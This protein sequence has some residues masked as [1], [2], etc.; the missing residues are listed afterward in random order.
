MEPTT[1][2]SQEEQVRLSGAIEVDAELVEDISSLI[3]SGQR[4]MVLNILTDLH[5]ADLSRILSHLNRDLARTSLE[6][7]PVDLASEVLAELDD[8]FR[9]ELADDMSNERLTAI[10]DEMESLYRGD[11]VFTVAERVVEVAEKMGVK[12]AQVAVAWLLTKPEV[13]SPIVGV[14]KVDQLE[15]LVEAS[16]LELAA[17][18]VAYM[19]E[20]YRPVE[21][22]LTLG[23][24]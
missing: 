18:D 6:W 24:S 12:P 16:K 13:T 7:L 23:S 19:E 15:Q 14:S 11:H 10:I 3:E 20:A 22:L 5:P 9:A 8:D 4:G 2:T 1:H 21:N 17:E